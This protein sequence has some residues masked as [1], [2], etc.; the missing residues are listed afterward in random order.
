LLLEAVQA[1][2]AAFPDRQVRLLAAIAPAL[3]PAA[4]QD[5]LIEGDWSPV[6]SSYPTF[7]RNNGVLVIAQDAF[8]EC[9]HLADAGIAT[10]GTATE[11]M[12]GL[13]KPV[14]TFPG[15][16]PQFTRTFAE[17]QSRL[18]G[19][20]VVLVPQPADVAAAMQNCLHDTH[21]LQRIAENGRHRMGEPGGAKQ[22]A[23]ALHKLYREPD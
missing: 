22:I 7:C 19:P 21:G 11:Q 5:A 17:V 6:A 18:L 1:V 15:K 13:G 8:A 23:L 10:A 20:S 16:G 4:F 9:L 12:V 14:F 3:N 2:M